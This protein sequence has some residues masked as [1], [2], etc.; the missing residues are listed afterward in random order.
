MS[1][2]AN[3]VLIDSFHLFSGAGSS[4]A[5]PPVQL[6]LGVPQP[7]PSPLRSNKQLCSDTAEKPQVDFVE[8][9]RAVA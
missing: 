1:F 3:H 6:H 8:G 2:N 4:A 5:Q 9:L 7:S